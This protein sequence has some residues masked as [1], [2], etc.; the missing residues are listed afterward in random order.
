MNPLQIPPSEAQPDMAANTGQ[1]RAP[2]P[3]IT[4]RSIVLG[5]TFTVVHTCWVIYEELALLHIGAPTLFTLVQ[6]VIGLLFVLMLA[7]SV[8]KRFA[9]RWVLSSAEMMVIFT[10]TTLGA[11][12]TASKL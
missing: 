11:I 10:M 9:P 7:N 3:G 4:R 6:T 1:F 12:I 2:V 5:L 8:L